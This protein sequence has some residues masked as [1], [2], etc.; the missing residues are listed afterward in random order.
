MPLDPQTARQQA[1][2][3]VASRNG[4]PQDV[5]R[6]AQQLINQSYQK[7]QVAIPQGMAEDD[8]PATNSVDYV[9][10]QPMMTARRGPSGAGDE[11]SYQM[12]EGTGLG[13]YLD[14]IMQAA[15]GDANVQSGAEAQAERA[16]AGT[17]GQ[18]FSQASQAG[19]GQNNQGNGRGQDRQ[20]GN[21]G[22]VNLPQNAPIP[23]GNPELDTAQ[24]EGW[25]LEDIAAGALG[26][27]LAGAAAAYLATRG[28]GKTNTAV[29]QTIDEQVADTKAT[30][31]TTS[32]RAEEEAAPTPTP[33]PLTDQ[34]FQDRVE[35]RDN[36]PRPGPNRF[37]GKPAVQSDVMQAIEGTDPSLAERAA[38]IPNQADPQ[39]AILEQ[40]GK[41]SG[42]DAVQF[43]RDNGID[44]RMLV[45]QL[46]ATV[47]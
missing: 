39:A 16:L 10:T 27:G 24:S 6:V 4:K 18:G 23:T 45:R 1:M 17:Q 41:M 28:K 13:N 20:G 15:F 12:A 44:P 37:S 32:P 3:I 47:R 38:S 43:L 11:V 40:A 36:T 34:Q 9:R 5:A 8:M 19:N 29:E 42:V 33:K 26:V 14:M 46:G 30:N 2:Q 21:N 31:A 35:G 7:P 22:G 25:S